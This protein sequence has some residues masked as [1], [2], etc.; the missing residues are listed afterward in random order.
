MLDYKNG[1]KYIDKYYDTMFNTL[2]VD[3]LYYRLNTYIDLMGDG[4]NE[5]MYCYFANEF[6]KDDPEYFADS[7]V[8]Y[9]FM[10]PYV[11]EG[12]L[13]V[14]LTNDEFYNE[15]SNKFLNYCNEN[16]EFSKEKVEDLL[17]QLKESL[18]NNYAEEP[19]V[20]R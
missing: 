6:S 1:K 18:K 20:K 7:G 12:E 4:V 15:V 16:S 19:T 13:K 11:D 5:L 2:R 17:S 3:Q 14:L 8:M 10:Y 9:S